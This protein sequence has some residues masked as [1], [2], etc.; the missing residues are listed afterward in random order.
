MDT[1]LDE[2]ERSLEQ[3]ERSMRGTL[4]LVAMQISAHKEFLGVDEAEDIEAVTGPD[5]P[6]K[7]H[8]DDLDPM[9]D[10]I[11]IVGRNTKF[12]A[13]EYW[14]K[15]WRQLH[16]DTMI[17]HNP[18]RALEDCI[19][20]GID[21]L[22]IRRNAS[23]R[24]INQRHDFV[25]ALNTYHKNWLREFKQD[26]CKV[27]T[28]HG[29]YAMVDLAIK[30]DKRISVMA[31]R[32]FC[33]SFAAVG[34]DIIAH[35]Q[36]IRFEIRCQNEKRLASKVVIVAH[37]KTPVHLFKDGKE[38]VAFDQKQLDYLSERGYAQKS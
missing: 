36:R 33:D 22:D 17:N 1:W 11:D 13:T 10:V 4:G 35:E 25:V 9:S 31:N 34:G 28:M 21:N 5:D 37:F 20:I 16:S 23:V 2:L 19:L 26:L 30:H 27:H 32:D 29:L 7:F 18:A 8:N 14:A 24:A 12:I 38:K 3:D 6:D 15:Q